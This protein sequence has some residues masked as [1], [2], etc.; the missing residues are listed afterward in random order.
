M[1]QD[2][3]EDFSDG[4]RLILLLKTLSQKTVGK[5]SKKPKIYA[6]MIDNIALALDFIMKKEHITLVNIGKLVTVTTNCDHSS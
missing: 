1:I 6:Q 5:Y 2:L 4:T 3:S